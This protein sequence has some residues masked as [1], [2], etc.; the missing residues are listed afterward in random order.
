MILGYIL[1]G[2]LGG[3]LAA[4]WIAVTGGSWL[5]AIGAFVVAGNAAVLMS[6]GLVYARMESR[7]RAAARTTLAT[8]VP[9][10]TQR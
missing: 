10:L 6:A 9:P 7:A 4:C 8:P 5:A 1:L 2:W 3:F